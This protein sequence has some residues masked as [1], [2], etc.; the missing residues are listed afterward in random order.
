M[1]EQSK[2]SWQSRTI[3]NITNNPCMIWPLSSWACSR[4]CWQIS[5]RFSFSSSDKNKFSCN[6]IHFLNVLVCHTDPSIHVN[7]LTDWT[8]KLYPIFFI[9]KISLALKVVRASESISFSNHPP[10][11]H[12]LNY[13]FNWIMLIKSVFWGFGT[14]LIKL[15]LICS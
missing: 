13:L 1:Y 5:T 11:M 14:W 4:S 10:N 3:M 9:R 15:M 7:V 2:N 6:S 12:L 8:K